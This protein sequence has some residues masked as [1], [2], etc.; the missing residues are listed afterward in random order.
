MTRSLASGGGGQLEQ[1][2]APFDVKRLPKSER[3]NIDCLKKIIGLQPRGP[4]ANYP[5]LLL[6]PPP[7]PRIRSCRSPWPTATRQQEKAG[8]Q[9]R[10][11]AGRRNYRRRRRRAGG[12]RRGSASYAKEEISVADTSGDHT[13]GRS[14]ALRR[15]RN[16][17]TA[18]GGT[19]QRNRSWRLSR[20]YDYERT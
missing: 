8:R 10:M 17:S 16:H 5:H 3:H 13:S 14:G 7:P 1:W 9:L 4:E 2:S 20:R 15:S 18:I 12:R 11:A 19:T 6:P